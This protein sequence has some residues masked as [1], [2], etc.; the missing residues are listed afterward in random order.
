[1]EGVDF[2]MKDLTPMLSKF[3]D[4]SG[5]IDPSK[6]P[7]DMTASPQNTADLSLHSQITLH[8]VAYSV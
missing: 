2:D 8:K 1:M 4:A 6:A 7:P 3:M 5:N